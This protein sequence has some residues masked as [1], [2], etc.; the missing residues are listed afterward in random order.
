MKR[1]FLLL[2]L[3]TTGCLFL[4]SAQG[5]NTAIVL[6]KL[7]GRLSLNIPDNEKIRAND[8]IEFIIDS[9]VR[10]DSVFD[11]KYTNLKYLGQII[12]RDVRLK[13]VSWNVLLKDSPSRY[14]CYFIN[15]KREG[16]RINKLISGYRKETI[17]TDTVYSEDNWYGALYYDMRPVK[18]DNQVYWMILGIDYGNPAITRKIIDVLSF[19]SKD[20]IIFGKKWFENGKTA[21]FREVLEYSFN[22]VI[23][24]R[25]L[26]DKL[27][28]FD[29]LVP[30][31]NG[32]ENNREFYGP[33]FSYDAYHFE[34]GAWQLRINVDA[35]NKE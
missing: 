21:K 1:I 6:E 7:F 33:D 14:Y 15:R 20:E 22:A 25:F 34:K 35:R 5:D 3:T 32:Y 13:I 28:V 26:S 8:S 29:H 17:R 2:L 19:N 31:S 9:Y 24:L 4:T 27:I 18:K 30:V 11:H 12:S 16:N 10:S 23:S